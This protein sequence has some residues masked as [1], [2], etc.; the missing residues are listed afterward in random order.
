LARRATA[1]EQ[2]RNQAKGAVLVLDAG[3]ALDGQWTARASEGKVMVEAMN[4]MGYDAL[5]IG[6]MDISLG[7]EALKARAAEAEFAVLSAN[8]VNAEDQ[9]PLFD[10]YVI[11]ERAGA[12][13]AVIG[14]T[15]AESFESPSAPKTA[16]LL[17]PVETAADYVAQLRGE[18]DVVIVL[19]HLGFE[20]DVALAEAVP[21]IDIIIGGNT[22]RL[23]NEPERV[24]NTLIIQQGYRGEWVGLLTAF[25]DG[26]GKLG[27]YGS[28]VL[29]LN[30]TYADDPGMVELLAG[31]RQAY[32]SPTP[33]PTLTPDPRTPTANMTQTVEALQTRAFEMMTATAAA[34]PQ[35]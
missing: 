13:Y 16:V 3:S 32:P 7:L 1:I 25:Y 17:D 27:D 9:K 34:A 8:L 28:E 5:T 12:R 14:L 23:M 2:A 31:Y 11:I 4:A 18:V 15:E 21:G 19:S 10:P 35:K 22:R 29:T 26:Q 33:R 30:D 6:R 24:G 20:P